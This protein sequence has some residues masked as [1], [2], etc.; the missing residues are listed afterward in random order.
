LPVHPVPAPAVRDPLSG[1]AVSSRRD[2]ASGRHG[3]HP[4]S[5]GRSAPDPHLAGR[6][7]IRR[8]ALAAPSPLGDHLRLWDLDGRAI[9]WT[10]QH[11]D[12]L[13][14]EIHSG[15]PPR[16]A[17]VLEAIF[18]DADA[19]VDGGSLA[20]WAPEDDPATVSALTTRGLRPTDDRLSQFQLRLGADGGTGAA[21]ED[22]PLP[23][24]YRLRSVTG[25]SE[26]EAR[27]L[28]HRAAFGTTRLTTAMY[29]RL[30]TLPH[31]D[32]ADDLVVEAPDGS[33]AAF[34]MAWWD[35]V[36][37]MGEFEP[38]GT[39]PDHRRLGLGGAVLRHGLRR[40]AARGADLVQVYSLTD[41][42]ASEALYASVG[43]RR[44]RFRRRYRRGP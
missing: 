14:W 16:D 29:E 13:H 25:V 2:R 20:A 5:R 10:W 7:A 30:M 37:R 28:V 18:D 11:G 23:D 41:N 27:T 19:A 44:R 3:P 42:A 26:L 33:M 43:F 15:D 35:P 36:S 12:Q 17:L 24:G 38:V 9:A 21:I 39:H 22:P 31:Y 40:Y 1:L 4:S 34:A 8:F 32:I 6:R